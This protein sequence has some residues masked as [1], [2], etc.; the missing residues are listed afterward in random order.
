VNDGQ[1]RRRTHVVTQE[2]RRG[3]GTRCRRPGG[4]RSS[5]EASRQHRGERR[6]RWREGAAAQCRRWPHE[7]RPSEVGGRICEARIGQRGAHRRRAL[8]R[9]ALDDEALDREG[10]FCEALDREAL[11]GE[12]VF[13]EALDRDRQA[14][15]YRGALDCKAGLDGEA[16]FEQAL[17]QLHQQGGFLTEFRVGAQAEALLEQAGVLAT[18]GEAGETSGSPGGV[19]P[20]ARAPPRLAPLAA[21]APSLLFGARA[22]GDAA[23]PSRSGRRRSF[24]SR[25]HALPPCEFA[26]ACCRIGLLLPGRSTAARLARTPL[27]SQNDDRAWP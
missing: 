26:R 5:E 19:R 24:P 7:G 4:S 20:G 27:S 10:V 18:T 23:S 17:E 15:S 8:D 16:R 6:E 1:R 3:R 12:G 9:E 22:P 25:A 11:D 13:C 21:L 14:R 2:G